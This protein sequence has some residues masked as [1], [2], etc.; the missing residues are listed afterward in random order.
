MIVFFEKNGQST[1]NITMVEH[2][3]MS[4]TLPA[5]M[6]LNEKIKYF[7]EKNMSYVALP[8]ELGG[9]IF[10]YKV[11]MNEKEEFIGLQ[12]IENEKE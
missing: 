12:P 7:D 3:V 10:N 1:R 5:N 11:C 9:A 6:E 8:Y 2:E 4:P